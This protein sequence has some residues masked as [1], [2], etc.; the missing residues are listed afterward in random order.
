MADGDSA[1]A[2]IQNRTKPVLFAFMIRELSGF[3]SVQNI[4]FSPPKKLLCSKV[5]VP[6]L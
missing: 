4:L 5:S 2:L 3:L 1:S 6:G